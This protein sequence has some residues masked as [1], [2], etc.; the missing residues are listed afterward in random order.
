M[1]LHR[2]LPD[3]L[4]DLNFRR[5]TVIALC[6]FFV[7][8]TL[9]FRSE[10]NIFD[11]GISLACATRIMDGEIPY[12]DYWALYTPGEYYLLAGFMSVFGKTMF[13]ER[14]AD[15]VVRL[16]LLL[17]SLDVLRRLPSTRWNKVIVYSIALILGGIALFTYAI[18]PALVFS[19]ST[20]L[21]LSSTSASGFSTRAFVAGLFA[22]LSTLFRLDFGAYTILTILATTFVL[23]VFKKATLRHAVMYILAVS[24]GYLVGILPLVFLSFFT[25]IQP[26]YEQL[27]KFPSGEL[28]A[29][30]HLSLPSLGPIF[31]ETDPLDKIIK[32]WLVMGSAFYGSICI[33]LIGL[34]LSVRQMRLEVKPISVLHFGISVLGLFFI[35]QAVNRCDHGH[36][37][38]QILCAIVGLAISLGYRIEES[39]HRKKRAILYFA[40]GLFVF[41]SL[42]PAVQRFESSVKHFE[43]WKTHNPLPV[44]SGVYFDSPSSNAV[45]YVRS[46]T[47]P[48]DY[49]LVVNTRHDKILLTN[50]IVY[51]LAE[52]RCPI[53]Y[54]D[55][56]H[57]IITRED[58]QR[59][60]I[61][62]LKRKNVQWLIMTNIKDSQEPNL[63][64]VSSGVHILDEYIRNEYAPD[65]TFDDYI[66]W[67]KK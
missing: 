1:N 47:K 38:P 20:L 10:P 66:V 46:V 34:G 64:S 63:T 37:I 50:V 35:A 11:E 57:G 26:L 44:S 7:S 54:H 17:L 14:S 16:I 2:F 30:R 39:W 58:V 65:R 15:I 28:L 9:V 4:T 25:G 56:H 32:R 3:T 12:R 33:N 24:C 51:F 18:F 8:M 19:F 62:S 67:K 21:L 53:P 43:I 27:Y 60:V 45:Q 49:I 23:F 31:T 6:I 42:I 61:D 55:I 40:V 5:T 52:R 48:N 13:V 59:E 29:I 41:W 22:G 36:C